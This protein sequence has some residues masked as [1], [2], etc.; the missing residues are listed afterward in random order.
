MAFLLKRGDSQPLIYKHCHACTAVVR[1]YLAQR[2]NPAFR[3]W[4]REL[5][6]WIIIVKRQVPA[7]ALRRLPNLTSVDQLLPL[8]LALDI[9]ERYR[10]TLMMRLQRM[11]NKSF[12][13]AQHVQN[14]LIS[15]LFVGYM[16]PMRQGVIRE[17]L[18]AGWQGDGTPLELFIIIIIIVLLLLL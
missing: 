11:E 17:A 12:E 5:L 16:P 7:A 3:Q 6:E 15:M 14:L 13:L 2:P 4:L 18:Y 8:S 9:Q 10:R 1:F